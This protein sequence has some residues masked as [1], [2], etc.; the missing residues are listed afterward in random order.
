MITFLKIIWESIAQAFQQLAANKLRTFLSL[1]G[2]TI[3]I[4]CIIGVKS[5]VDSLE[6]D[7]RGSFEK[8]GRNVVYI[9]KFP[10]SD[11]SLKDFLK[12]R[13][14]PNTSFD[15][16]K[17]IEKRMKNADV[18]CFMVM[19]E[20]RTLQYLNSNI[21][22]ATVS[23]ATFAFD[24]IFDVEIEKGRYFSPT[25]Y[26]YG[27]NKCIIGA[28]IAEELFGNDEPIGKK[29]KMMGRKVEV[30]GVIKKSG[31]DLIGV[32]NF[33]EDVIVS[34]ELMRKVSNLNT[35]ANFQN[36]TL[37]V[38]AKDG[39]SMDQF[40]DEITGIMRAHRRLKPSQ[41]SNFA[42]NEL[43]M[44]TNIFEIIFSSLNNM[45]FIV[46]IFAILVGMFS[47]ANIMFVSVKERTG[48]IGIKKALGAKKYIIMLEFLIESIILCILGGLFGLL[49]IQVVVKVLSSV[50]GFE[51][52]L[53]FSNI[54][55]GLA[56][57]IGIG[58]IAGLIPAFRAASMDP[59][60][61]MRS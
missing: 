32:G 27:A 7:I 8:L 14:R 9:S 20:M 60:T 23:G 22:S 41:E 12:W 43:S 45:A 26:H 38:R 50:L 36:A 55:G 40:K 49:L 25:E 5:A 10:W 4:F 35:N 54:I 28:T 56:W 44:M 31:E 57:S 11:G 37:A 51:I 29:I 1:L 6:T 42:V 18:A 17:V 59:V 53:S 16:F 33:D 46:G 3:G 48:L 34:L 61:A 52:Y 13:R 24:E 58:I 21:E 47:V 19:P 2:I 15:D 30:I 39:I